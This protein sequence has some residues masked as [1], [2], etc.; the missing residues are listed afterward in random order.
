[1]WSI[2]LTYVSQIVIDRLSFT[3]YLR[4]LVGGCEIGMSFVKKFTE[5]FSLYGS[6]IHKR[7]HKLETT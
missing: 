6:G 7:V 3:S 4:S 2:S 5:L 1:M